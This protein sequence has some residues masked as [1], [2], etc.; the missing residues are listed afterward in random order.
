[1]RKVILLG[2]TGFVGSH[3]YKSL[4]QTLPEVPLVG[5]SFPELDLTRSESVGI[6][7]ALFDRHTVVILCSGIKRQFGDSPDIFEKNVAMC[8]NV[9]R[10]L[11]VSPVA[12]MVFFSSM[13]VY[14]EDIHN[15][16][17][18]EN[19]PIC[20]RS[21]YGLAKYV[22]ELVFERI[23]SRQNGSYVAIRLP[24]IYGPGD[25]GNTYGP[26]GFL[27]AAMEGRVVTLWG[28]GEE[29]REFIFIDD[30]VEIVKRLLT[31]EYQGVVNVTAG[32]SYSFR[33][34]LN[35][36]DRLLPQGVQ[37]ASRARSKDKVDNASCNAK[38]QQWTGGFVFTALEDGIRKMF[39]VEKSRVKP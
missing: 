38:I 25:G 5:S 21:Y 23:F 7:K 35:I 24:V 10:A 27:K 22:G 18:D 37:V 2:H 26:A 1:M 29:L 31:V 19:T 30:V 3:L 39:E 34:I 36:L 17:I 14:G 13:A 8:L 28:D 15:I 12:R 4:V 6:L 9:V 20:P 32:K 16:G 11:E 33:D